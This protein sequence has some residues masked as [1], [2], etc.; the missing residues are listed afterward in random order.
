MPPSKLTGAHLS[1]V[2]LADDWK[3]VRDGV[4]GALICFFLTQTKLF[5]FM[6]IEFWRMAK[7]SPL[8]ALQLITGI[9]TEEFPNTKTQI[10]ARP[11]SW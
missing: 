10:W 11:Q 6:M 5:M 8:C 7:I 4:S 2:C 9:K 1:E 3:S